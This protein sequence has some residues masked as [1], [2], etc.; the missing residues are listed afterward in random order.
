MIVQNLKPEVFKTVGDATIFIDKRNLLLERV[1]GTLSDVTFRP[2]LSI[3][4]K[5]RTL[6]LSEMAFA[7]LCGAIGINSGF[8]KKLNKLDAVKLAEVNEILAKSAQ[9]QAPVPLTYVVN[10]ENNALEALHRYFPVV[11]SDRKIIELTFDAIERV[12]VDRIVVGFVTQIN[13][14]SNLRVDIEPSV[15]EPVAVG[16]SILTSEFGLSPFII[17]DYYLKLS[18]TNGCVVAS[19]A[20]DR[21][22]KPEKYKVVD[23]FEKTVRQNTLF[24]LG[25]VRDLTKRIDSLRN[26]H[27]N[28][29]EAARVHGRIKSITKMTDEATE[30]LDFPK[31]EQEMYS[32]HPDLK[33]MDEFE[34]TKLETSYEVIP[35]WDKITALANKWD[36]DPNVCPRLQEYA[37]QFLFSN[38]SLN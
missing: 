30:V 9:T 7:Q 32:K 24:A 34:L 36:A 19:K 11:P 37:G 31:I 10:S 25:S 23:E 38:F 16:L 15:G 26:C 33:I 1:I 35:T 6:D 21:L 12:Q 17:R 14:L 8:A 29:V 3:Q 18:C 4:L 13:Y 22:F 20:R 2:D 5:G 27:L 28:F